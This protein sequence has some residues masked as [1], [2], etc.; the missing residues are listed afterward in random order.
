MGEHVW[1]HVR[2]VALL[3]LLV[4]GAVA[5]AMLVVDGGSQT[6]SG[7]SAPAV[8]QPAAEPPRGWPAAL[9]YPGEPWSAA[10][11]PGSLTA[12][13]AASGAPNVGAEVCR[14]RLTAAGFEAGEVKRLSSTV[15]VLT[16]SRGRSSLTATFVPFPNAKD[17]THHS[18]VSVGITDDRRQST[19]PWFAP[20]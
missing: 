16:A 13:F 1:P 5:G 10:E 20:R 4:G 2:G 14:E 19:D 11:Q 17:P 6:G 12:T 3:V 15:A 7:Y 18:L 9:D 8:R